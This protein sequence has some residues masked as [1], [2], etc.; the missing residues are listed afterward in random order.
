MISLVVVYVSVTS[1]PLMV[2][3][4]V[5]WAKSCDGFEDLG[6]NPALLLAAYNRK[7]EC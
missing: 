3:V 5:I 7:R 4:S 6:L 1:L 2:V